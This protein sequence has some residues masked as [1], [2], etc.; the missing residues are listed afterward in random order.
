MDDPM[1]AA[2]R[3]KLGDAT[4]A[5]W[6][7]L[8]R[9]DAVAESIPGK[10]HAVIGMRRAGKTSFLLQCLQDRLASGTPRDRL[11]YFNFEDER[12][13]GLAAAELGTLLDEYY[14]ALP[15]NRREHRVTWC[16]DEIQLIPGWEAFVR[17]ILDAENVEVFVSGSSAR[18]LSR[19]VATSLRGRALETVI[20]PFSLREFGR[21]AGLTPP[22]NSLWDATETSN[23]LACFD[24]YLRTG[25]F[26]ELARKELRPRQTELLQ[27]YVETVVFRDVAERHQLT[28]LL[29][30]RAFVRQLLRQP[31]SLLSITKLHSDFRS[32]GI[33]VS[34]EMLMQFLLHL[35]D[36]F[37]VFTVP[38]ATNSE[39]KQQVNLRKLYVADHALAAAFRGRSSGDLGHHLENMVACE[40]V[41]RGMELTY[42]R[43][44]AGHAVDFLATDRNGNAQLIQ[45]TADLLDRDT[46]ERELRALAGAAVEH[47]GAEPWLLVGSDLPADIAV[48]PGIRTMTIWRW[49]LGL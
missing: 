10:A 23:W 27:G 48:P 46:L 17:R 38:L 39:R 15:H 36:A 44:A 35:E 49:L 1:R 33:S 28:N 18:M 7:T 14:R 12:L 2:I 21:A 8:T 25:G 9:R 24:D 5:T 16:L 6:P 34:K 41:R 19:E 20:T 4:T 31:A 45:V 30:L 43:T 40:L 22:T 29:A 42:V 32:R 26:P 11:V 37:L 13:S 47:P 3:Q